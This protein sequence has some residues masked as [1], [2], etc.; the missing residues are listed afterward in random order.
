MSSA[1]I[2]MGATRWASAPEEQQRLGQR[3][4]QSHTGDEQEYA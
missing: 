1:A 4:P 2:Q 3:S